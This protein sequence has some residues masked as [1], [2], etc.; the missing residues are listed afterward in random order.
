MSL[1]RWFLNLIVGNVGIPGVKSLSGIDLTHQPLF[2]P[3]TPP[4]HP[5]N[6]DESQS[7]GIPHPPAAAASAAALMVDQL[8]VPGSSFTFRASA[9]APNDEQW[10][11]NCFPLAGRKVICMDQLGRAFR[12]DEETGQATIMS[13]LHKPK[14]MPLALSV[15]NADADN[16]YNLI[17]GTGAAPQ[18][19]LRH[20]EKE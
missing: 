16:D 4:T 17:A 9:S 10:K 6:D 5:P 12:F 8:L 7:H 1:S 20:G 13:S 19:P 2:N 18:Q 3:T 11:I 14:S 15:P